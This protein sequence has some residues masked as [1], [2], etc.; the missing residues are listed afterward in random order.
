MHGS[1]KDFTSLPYKNIVT[2]S[3][4]TS[5]TFDLDSELEI[6]FSSLGKV[7]FKFT[8]KTAIVEISKLIF[9]HIVA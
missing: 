7:K 2:Y 8:G 5:G 4:E 9:A 1:K 6:Y 3:V